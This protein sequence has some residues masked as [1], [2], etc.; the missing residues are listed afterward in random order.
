MVP[1]AAKNLVNTNIPR[2]N[3]KEQKRPNEPNKISQ[4]QPVGAIA[5]EKSKLT[6]L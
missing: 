3:I 6:T 5:V 2:Q 4:S 1:G